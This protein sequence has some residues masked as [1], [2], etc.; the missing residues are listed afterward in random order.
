[1]NKKGNAQDVL[2][3]AVFLFAT[4][5]V[6]FVINFSGN[7]ISTNLANHTEI[8]GTIAQPPIDNIGVQ[9]DKLDV[10]IFTIF[11]GLILG[12]IITSWFIAGHQARETNTHRY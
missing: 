3:I 8:N 9:V 11:M 7:L 12:M 10:I 2:W 4:A 1:M 5:I 6:L